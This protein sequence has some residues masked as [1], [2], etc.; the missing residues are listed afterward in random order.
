MILVSRQ[1]FLSILLILISCQNNSLQTYSIYGYAQGTT[2]VVKYNHDQNVIQKESIDSLLRNIDLS[3]SSYIDT[4]ILSLINQGYN[5]VLDSLITKVLQR[6]IEICYETDGMFDVTVAPLVEYWGFGP[7]KMRHKSP[8][9]FNFSS[10]FIGC[11]KIT[12]QKNTL[13]KS[14]SISID[15][16]G[17]AQGFTVDYLSQYLINHNINDF[18]IEVGGEIRCSGDNLG[19]GWKI[20]IDKP[21]DK[22]RDFAFILNL[23]DISLATSG[24]YRNYYYSDAIKISHTINPKTLQPANNELI[25]VTIL[26]P[27]CMSA[28]AYATACMSF[29]LQEAQDFLYKNSIIGCLI[30]VDKGDTLSYFTS[31]FSSFLHRSPGS[32]PQ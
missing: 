26:Y 23:E 8:Q 22:K 9:E 28:D 12:L 21:I 7:N 4:S 17:I 20:G 11:N 30:Y 18:M 19:G 3:M 13:F 5:I 14:D 32:A 2:Y 25:S 24:S 31:G 1:L 29:G 10:D 27:D 15:L 6:S 16:N